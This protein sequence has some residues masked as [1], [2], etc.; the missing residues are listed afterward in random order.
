MPVRELGG[1]AVEE[2]VDEGPAFRSPVAFGELDRL[3]ED[4]GDRDVR[5]LPGLDGDAV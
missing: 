5:V 4:H 2:A 3:V 1:R